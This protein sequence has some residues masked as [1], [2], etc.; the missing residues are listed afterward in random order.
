MSDQPTNPDEF[1][2]EDED[3]AGDGET[4]SYTAPDEPLGSH[5]F[6]TTSAEEREGES[7]D[8]RDRHTNPEVFERDA[9]VAS[10]VGHLVQPGDEDVDAIDLETNTVA[11]DEGDDDEDLSAEEAAMHTTDDV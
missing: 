4:A 7:F 10:D 2:Y 8:S 1:D 6:G 5:A 11:M 3:P 9:Y